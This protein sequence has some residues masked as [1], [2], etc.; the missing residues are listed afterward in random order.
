MFK[1]NEDTICKGFA[2]QIV[3]VIAKK[4]VT[5]NSLSLIQHSMKMLHFPDDLLKI[6]ADKIKTLYLTEEQHLDDPFIIFDVETVQKVLRFVF[7]IIV[8]YQLNQHDIEKTK[9]WT[10]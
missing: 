9:L 4:V 10:R 1:S 6:S 3:D 7:N 5:D 8:E 2:K